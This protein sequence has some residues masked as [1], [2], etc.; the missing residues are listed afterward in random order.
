ME[1]LW[2]ISPSSFSP[3][4]R[5]ISGHFP[6]HFPA[7]PHQHHS[8][9]LFVLSITDDLAQLKELIAIKR[10][11]NNILAYLPISQDDGEAVYTLYLS[12]MKYTHRS[13][14]LPLSRLEGDWWDSELLGFTEFET[15]DSFLSCLVIYVFKYI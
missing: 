5:T 4:D 10:L 14:V 6:Q 3:H 13:C 12:L 1:E 8:A 9:P 15:R 11:M 2:V 7:R